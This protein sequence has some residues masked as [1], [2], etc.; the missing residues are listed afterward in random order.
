MFFDILINKL[1]NMTNK[2]KAIYFIIGI[3]GSVLIN[4]IFSPFESELQT[5]GYGIIDFEFAWNNTTMQVILNAWSSNM[6]T[7]RVYLL[8]DMV[9]PIFYFIMISGWTLLIYNTN[10]KIGKIA[11]VSGML[12]ALSDYVENLFSIYIL[13]ITNYAS[14]APTMVSIFASLKFILLIIAIILNIYLLILFL[15]RKLRK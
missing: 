5:K 1:E 6:H 13:Y 12:A 10:I 8:T 15:L 7:I 11:I 2:A 4:M 14:I 3:L 9:Y